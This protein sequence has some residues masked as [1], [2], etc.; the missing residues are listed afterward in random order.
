MPPR[1][2]V[3][4]VFTN[5]L[6]CILSVYATY[7]SAVLSCF[8]FIVTANGERWRTAPEVER[9]PV[10]A[11]GF[12]AEEIY[13]KQAAANESKNKAIFSME[14]AGVRAFSFFGLYQKEL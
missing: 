11:K 12:A 7:L 3:L 8:S 2:I 5:L 14:I 6:Y 10:G 4:S 9:C 1:K 13:L